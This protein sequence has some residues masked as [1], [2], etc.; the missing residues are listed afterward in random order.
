MRFVKLVPAWAVTAVV[1]V[2]PGLA[3]NDESVDLVWLVETL[4]GTEIESKQAD[5]PINPASVAKLATTLWAL[6]RLG[7]G[8]RYTTTFAAEGELDPATGVLNGDLVV[9]GT[10]D[11]DF[12]VENAVMVAAELNRLGLRE[13]RGDVRLERFTIGWEGG[14]EGRK[15]NPADREAQMKARLLGAFDPDGWS[16]GMRRTI[17]ASRKRRGTGSEPLPRIVVHGGDVAATDEAPRVLVVHRSNPLRITLKRLNAYSNNDIERLEAALGPA[18]EMAG[19][20]SSRWGADE[21][22]TEFETLSGLGKN[23]ATPR[24]IGRLVRDLYETCVRLGLRIEDILPTAGCG[25][26]TL[27]NYR[28]LKRGRLST[29]VTAKT[30]TL[31]KTDGGVSVLAGLVT[32]RQGPTVFAVVAPRNGI[33]VWRARDAQQAWLLDLVRRRG[34]AKRGTCGAPVVY[35]DHDASVATP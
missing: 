13:V 20:L 6:E 29:A 30:G 19:F 23:R 35:S 17:H 33:E 16:D 15:E 24:Q 26:S 11:P 4:G 31:L 12:H 3:A 27:N 9:R 8:Y 22:A 28:A 7:P 10:D 21:P 34:G 32:T 5:E 1:A 14:S 2:T 25:P 18:A